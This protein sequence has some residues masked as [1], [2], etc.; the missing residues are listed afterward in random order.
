M[1]LGGIIS[2]H[3]R[4]YFIGIKGTGMCALA[5]LLHHSGA[6]VSGSDTPEQ[7][8]TDG[9]LRDLGIPFYEGFSPLHVPADAAL[10]IHSAAYGIETNSEMAEVQR[11]GIPLVKYP[12]AL[13]AYSALFDSSGI[14]G[15]HGK[16][17]TT[18]MTGV[19]FR[20]AALPARVLAGSAV[21][22][23]G[24]RSTLTLGD[25]YFAA[26]TC[27]YRRHF[28][29]FHPRR[30]V[31]TSVESDHQDYFPRYADIR[32]AFVE[33]VLKLPPGGELIYCA[34]DPGA[35]ETADRAL[36][37]RGDIK[38]LPYGFTAPGEYRIESYAVKDERV[39]F[40]LGGFYRSGGREKMPFKLRIPG[41]H[42]VLDAAGAL[43]LTDR[44]ARQE[45]GEQGLPLE[46][47]ACALEEFGGSRRRSE[48]L[49]QAGGILFMDDYGHHPTALRT[50]LRGLKEFYPSRRIV[51]SFMS[52]TYTRTAAMLEDFASSFLFA[53][54]VFLHKIYPSA[55]ESYTGGVT[56][57][58]LYE[59]TLSLR[60]EVYYAEESEDAAGELQ[61]ILRDGDLF[62]TMGAGDNWRLG[63]KLLELYRGREK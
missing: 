34:D 31:L 39:H 8:Y 40:T 43:A 33:Y 28:L 30:I 50:T 10:G 45:F 35:C 48:I 60:G 18:A 61:N 51:L 57:R 49:G 6:A 55:R 9:I 21:S 25:K 63:K 3:K 62:I 7:F 13:G 44:L 2:G 5:E 36:K 27:E 37:V 11:R 59:K 24:G 58:T 26:E 46:Q 41:K 53:D 12:D 19:L 38:F 16:T 20:A 42:C 32:D 14:A 23:F 22:A 54:I 4:V 56:G 52:H 47:A 29:A 1:D 17:T 15:V